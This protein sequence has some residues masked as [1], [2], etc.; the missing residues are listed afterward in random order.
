VVVDVEATSV[1]VLAVDDVAL[2]EVAV[3][4]VAMSPRGKVPLK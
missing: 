3:L 1:V 2:L 4:V